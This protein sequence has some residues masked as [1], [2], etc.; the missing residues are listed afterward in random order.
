MNRLLDKLVILILCL[1]GVSFSDSYTIPVAVIL[2]SV[3]ASALVQIFAGKKAASLAILACCS[4]CFVTPM[5]FCAV[6]LMLY[7]ALWEKKW[8][9]VLPSLGTVLKFEQLTY[10]QLTVTIAGMIGAVIIYKRIHGLESAVEKLTSQHDSITEKNI[11]LSQQNSR[12][13]KAQDNEVRLAALRER[14]RI[15]REIHDNVGHM[16]TRSLLQSGAII[17]TNKDEALR[18]PLNELKST[19]DC[20]MTG[21]RESVHDLRDGSIDLKKVLEEIIGSAGSGFITELDYDAGENVPGKIKLCVAGIVKE[22][23]SNAVKHSNGDRISA[24]FREHPGFYQLSVQ[25]NG[26]CKN[27]TAD[28]NGMGLKNMEERADMAGGRISFTPSEKGFR[29]FMSV[30]KEL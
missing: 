29:V 3:S 8:W 28:P 26:N 14:N 23:V 21:I 13:V 6:P 15:A 20:A 12:I 9:L 22:S 24:V 17:V 10:S 25:D 16:L 30:P 2:V 27:I 19:L 1:L 5:F 4:M 11:K 7:D 18:E